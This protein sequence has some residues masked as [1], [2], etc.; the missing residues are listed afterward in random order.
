LFVEKKS[1]EIKGGRHKTT[2]LTGTAH[3]LSW[4][5]TETKAREGVTMPRLRERP[6]FGGQKKAVKEGRW[7]AKVQTR[8]VSAW[9]DNPQ[10]GFNPG[11]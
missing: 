11:A 8:F 7:E 1:R 2:R 6:F 3:K 10:V 5:A 9:E 4:L